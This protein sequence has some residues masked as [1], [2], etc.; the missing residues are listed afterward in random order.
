MP[1][2]FVINLAKKGS[3]KTLLFW[4]SCF[5]SNTATDFLDIESEDSTY[6]PVLQFDVRIA[7]DRIPKWRR[8]YSWRLPELNKS[9]ILKQDT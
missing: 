8:D 3:P 6:N 4:N 1:V 5:K 7:L 9:K 2:F